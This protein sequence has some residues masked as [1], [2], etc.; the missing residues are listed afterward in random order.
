MRWQWLEDVDA[1]VA[2]HPSAEG[3][4]EAT[5]AQVLRCRR[6]LVSGIARLSPKDALFLY[7]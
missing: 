7:P 1:T 5:G 6:L 3:R 2:Q 4:Q